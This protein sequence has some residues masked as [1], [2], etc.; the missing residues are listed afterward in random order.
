M[1]KANIKKYFFTE[2]VIKLWSPLPV[3]AVQI[4]M[5]TGLKYGHDHFMKNISIPVVKH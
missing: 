1:F 2:C 3:H 5:N 4:K